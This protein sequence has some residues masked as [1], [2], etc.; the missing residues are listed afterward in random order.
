[1]NKYELVVYDGKA[2]KT[3]EVEASDCDI[4]ENVIIFFDVNGKDSYIVQND[5]WLSVKCVD[6]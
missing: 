6:N 2:Y 1:M 3:E 5:Y 4:R